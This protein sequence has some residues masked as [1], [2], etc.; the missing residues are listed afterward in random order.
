M[1]YA[2]R[3]KD[4]RIQGIAGIW[5]SVL[6]YA[7]PCQSEMMLNHLFSQLIYERNKW[8]E[9]ARV[10][11]YLLSSIINRNRADVKIKLL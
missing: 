6:N 7:K 5:V 3:I 8:L 11:L 9:E 2:Q 1:L 4:Q 10:F